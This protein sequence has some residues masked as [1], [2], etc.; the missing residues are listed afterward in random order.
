M[1]SRAS[2]LVVRI[3][4]CLYC[5]TIISCGGGTGNSPS[6]SPTAFSISGNI[7]PGVNVS[8]A[9]ITLSG[10]AS[11][12]TKA[13]SSGNY[14]FSAL[15]AGFY[16]LTPS[17]AGS[18]FS[19]PSQGVMYG[20]GATMTL[21]GAANAIT[22]ADGSGNYSFR[23][24][25]TGSYTLT[26]SKPGSS[27]TPSSRRITANGSDIAAVNF[28]A[29][30][31][32]QSSGPIVINGQNGT[33][34]EGLRITSNSGACVTIT[35]STNITIQNSEIGPCAG[36]G[37]AIS[38]GSGIN[39]FDSYIHPEALASA[40]CDRNDGIFATAGTQNLWIQGNII[41]YGGSNIVVQGGINVSVT[42]NLLLNPQGPYPRGSN[43]Q[44]W[45]NCINITVQNN[46]ALSS[47]DAKYLYSEATTDSISFGVTAGFVAQNNFITGG[48][49]VS[50]CGIMADTFS[51]N[52][53][54]LSNSLLNT[55]QCGIGITDGSHIANGNKVYNT[56]PVS[57]GGNTAM[58]VAH[59]GKS[60]TCGPVTIINNVTDGLKPN[61]THS[62]WW[63]AGDCGNIDIATD[64]FA[65][66][67][68]TLLTPVSVVFVP[69]LIPPQPKNCV[70]T[71]PYSTQTSFP[72]CVP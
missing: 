44:C 3:V 22:T 66:S 20:N 21:S 71:S 24:L 29:S 65:S 4:V 33:V 53:Q 56:N 42:G 55:G 1:I 72:P 23:A 30:S 54:I 26:P 31:V 61:G 11:A 5:F 46:Y 51:N 37:I 59:Y 16:A 45:N 14:S 40:C 19:P 6:G 28:T 47:N 63:E 35:N 36:N 39:I 9:T 43:F 10:A 52:G 70:V 15:S 8:G 17:K 7:S 58:Y 48:H 67:A 34:I 50:G 64:T 13:N 49:S 62:G 12:T 38:G 41:A 27:F 2:D 25:S 32:G 69:P 57:G 60:A 68:D 18:S